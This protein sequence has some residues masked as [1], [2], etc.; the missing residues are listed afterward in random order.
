MRHYLWTPLLIAILG[1]TWPAAVQAQQAPADD[2]R[3][4][5]G[6]VDYL[7]YFATRRI[8][9]AVGVELGMDIG[10]QGEGADEIGIDRNVGHKPT[11][12]SIHNCILLG[13][14]KSKA[15]RENPSLNIVGVSEFRLKRSD[16]LF[17]KLCACPCC[18]PLRSARAVRK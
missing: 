12:Q 5:N 1:L 14:M 7:E 16:K 8:I 11:F 13:C 6:A 18:P 15:F 3:K 10:W 2:Q 9:E 4:L 17:R